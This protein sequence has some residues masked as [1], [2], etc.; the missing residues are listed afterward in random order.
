MHV[1]PCPGPGVAAGWSLPSRVGELGG[2]DNET[3]A[4]WIR[5][6]EKYRS[7]VIHSAHVPRIFAGHSRWENLRAHL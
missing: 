3:G 1:G 4:E 2:P 5:A 6:A 7:R